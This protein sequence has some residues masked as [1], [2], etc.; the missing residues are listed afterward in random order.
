MIKKAMKTYPMMKRLFGEIRNKYILSKIKKFQE[1]AYCLINSTFE[2]KIS[3]Y[4][5]NLNYNYYLIFA[6]FL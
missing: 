3:T 5:E 4:I 6:D 2:W 1:I